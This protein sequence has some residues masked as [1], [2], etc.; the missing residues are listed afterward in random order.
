MAVVPENVASYRVLEHIGFA[1]EETARY[2]DLEVVYYSITPGQ[3][4]H[5]DSLFRETR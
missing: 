2:Y 4:Q 3:F 1:Y 5:E